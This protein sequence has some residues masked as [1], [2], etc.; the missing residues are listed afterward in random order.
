LKVVFVK[1]RCDE[2]VAMM[3][4][5]SERPAPPRRVTTVMPRAARAASMDA[6]HGR[7]ATE[8]DHLAGTGGHH[9]VDGV[10]GIVAP[11]VRKTGCLP[12]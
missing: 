3:R 6:R 4:E 8:D 5:V 10:C 2:V 7:G 11:A 1:P 9:G 12:L